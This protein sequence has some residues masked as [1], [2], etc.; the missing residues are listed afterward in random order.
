MARPPKWML[1]YRMPPLRPYWQAINRQEREAQAQVRANRKAR[2]KRRAKCRCDAYRFP[3]R[4]GGGLCRHPDPP[5]TRWQDA[6][7]AQIA[8]EIDDFRQ[9]I[10]HEP[11]EYQKALIT[12]SI[13]RPSRAYRRRY[14][15][16]RRQIARNNGFHPIRDRAAIDRLVPWALALAKQLHDQ[17]PKHKYR[18][19]TITDKGI[20]AH[21]T[22][23]GPTM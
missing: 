13:K 12:Q 23:A 11:T 17:F 22:T 19:M 4:P 14:A 16:R 21:W 10:G 18:N 15:G 2:D 1:D 3:H 5:A 6:Q 9:Q 7:A 8:E 20:T